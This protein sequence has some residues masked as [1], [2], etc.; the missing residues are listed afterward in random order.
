MTK[1]GII[2]N[3]LNKEFGNLTPVVKRDKT[4]YVDKNRTP[5]FFYYQDGRHPRTPINYYRLWVFFEDIFGLKHHQIREILSIWLEDTYNLKG[6]TETY[7]NR[8]TYL[9]WNISL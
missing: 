2:L 6:F 1:Y 8:Y 9:D 5:I 4:F 3:W 7:S